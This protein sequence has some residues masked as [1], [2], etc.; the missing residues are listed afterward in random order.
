MAYDSKFGIYDHETDVD[1]N[2]LAGVSLQP[3]EEF[4]ELS[5]LYALINRFRMQNLGER[6]GL[7]L[8][9]YLELPLH[10]QAMMTEQF[11]Q[12]ANERKKAE[13]RLKNEGKNNDDNDQAMQPL[14]KS[15]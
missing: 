6:M 1:E 13:E 2:P 3:K 12:E 4:F 5:G 10:V 8:V 9:D 11:S 7:S 15:E 14:R